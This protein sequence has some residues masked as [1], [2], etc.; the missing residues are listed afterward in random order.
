MFLALH[1]MKH[2]KLRYGMVIFMIMLISYLVFVLAALALGLANQEYQ[3]LDTWNV[4]SAVM[5]TTSDKEL[6]QSTLTPQQVKNLTKNQDNAVI[7]INSVIAK[8]SGKK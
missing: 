8:A 6:R 5:T 7:A 1:E 3:A 2:E 4:K